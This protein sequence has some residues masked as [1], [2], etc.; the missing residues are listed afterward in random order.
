MHI[1]LNR[2]G[3]VVL[4]LLIGGNAGAAV[5]AQGSPGFRNYPLI[6]DQTLARMR[7]GFSV[8]SPSGTLEI[9]FAIRRV[10]YINGQLQAVTQLTLPSL[11]PALAAAPPAGV[12]GNGGPRAPAT[13]PTWGAGPVVTVNGAVTA[14]QNGPGNT[15]ELAGLSNL[16][17]QALTVI[18]NSL[19]NQRIQNATVIDATVRNLALYKTLNLSAQISQGLASALR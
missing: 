14:I 5:L 11:T 13:A 19:D 2:I 12:A 7:G 16:T 10:T 9:A 15:A 17:H 4:S 8:P 1:R 6:A 3:G 18:Q